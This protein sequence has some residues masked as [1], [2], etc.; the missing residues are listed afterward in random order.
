MHPLRAVRK[1]LTVAAC[2]ASLAGAVALLGAVSDAETSKPALEQQL[3]ARHLVS[4]G[5]VEV[6]A[7]ASEPCMGGVASLVK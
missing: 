4:V 2:L 7:P 6:A 3:F 1:L 5:Q